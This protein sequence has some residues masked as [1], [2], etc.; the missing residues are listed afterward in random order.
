[1]LKT[2]NNGN[3]ACVS[4]R[5]AISIY[6]VTSSLLDV[7]QSRDSYQSWTVRSLK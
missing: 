1:M 6:I 4:T 3:V 5:D 2:A 7:E